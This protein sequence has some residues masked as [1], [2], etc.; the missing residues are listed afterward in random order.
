VHSGDSKS[1]RGRDVAMSLRL[2]SALRRRWLELG[3][4]GPEEHVVVRRDPKRFRERLLVRVCEAAE[5]EPFQPKQLRDS[6]GSYLLTAG[7]SLGYIAQ[8]LGHSGPHVTARHY[9]RYLGEGVY[10]VPMELRGGEVP[11]DFLARF[12]KPSARRSV[13]R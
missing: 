7:V 13:A 2:R 5:V 3:K 6:F 1:G 8:Q 12:G 9:A 4:P 10:R 11:A